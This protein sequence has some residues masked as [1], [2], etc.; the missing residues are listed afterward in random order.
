MKIPA[1]IL[2]SHTTGLAVIRAL[3]QMGVPIIVIYYEK[4]DM[5]QVSKYVKER[6]FAPHPE[7]FEK[8]FIDLLTKSSQRFGK[9]LLIP[10]DDPTLVVVSKNKSQLKKH[11]HVGCTEWQI[12]RKFIDKKF[13]YELAESNGI[14][15]PKTIIPKSIEDL[16]RYDKKIEYPC[17]VK[18]RQS[19][20]YSKL[21]K[22]KMTRVENFNQLI[23]A[24]RDATDVGIEVL[25]QELIP[26]DDTQNVN[27]NS[28]FWESKPLVEFTAEK[29]RLSPP[30]FGVP[31]IV[32]SKY[33]PEIIKPGRQILQAMGFYG[34][35]CTEFKKDTR[36]GVYKLMEVN[37]RHN[38]SGI[39]SVRCGINF[40]WIEY[41]H[42]T[43]RE[44]PIACSYQNG[45]Y[46]IDEF[47]DIVHNSK[48]IIKER[49]SL[50]QY[51]RPYQRSHI[52]S[53][54]DLQDPIPFIKRCINLGTR[55]L[56]FIFHFL[57]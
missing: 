39:L 1:V 47:R 49:Y 42:L 10:A 18:P 55:T 24:Y 8:E 7:K 19:H 21:F 26:G 50:F 27:Y 4:I 45:I 29:I 3:G 53:T 13:T 31:S 32:I 56:N 20:L 33:I 43:Q 16:E 22:K 23:S 15:A 9:C 28:Y 46:W 41:K 2:S 38:R 12:T 48:Y 5:G 17:L 52:F 36:D 51:L 11:F 57:Q 54:F 40:P 35:S 14:P 37:G 25:I 6:I 34:Y 44:L 30:K